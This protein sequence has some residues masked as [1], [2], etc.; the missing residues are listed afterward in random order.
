MGYALLNVLSLLIAIVT[1][2]IGVYC[3]SVSKGR[4]YYPALTFS[5][6]ALFGP[7][8]LLRG[9][10][11]CFHGCENASWLIRHAMVFFGALCVPSSALFL[12]WIRKAE[13]DSTNADQGEPDH[14][15]A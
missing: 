4:R 6:L 3:I 2:F 12:I 1:L 7:I 9:N 8:I 14:G 15:A 13:E 5:L 11:N 10:L